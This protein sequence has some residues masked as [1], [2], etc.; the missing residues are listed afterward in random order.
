MTHAYTL[1]HCLNGA[2]NGSYINLLD[3]RV[4]AIELVDLNRNPDGAE[5]FFTVLRCLESL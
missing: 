2:V 1:G 3:L 4:L 5:S